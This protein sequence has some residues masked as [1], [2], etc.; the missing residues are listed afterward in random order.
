MEL[1]NFLAANLCL[2]LTLVVC[3]YMLTAQIL[4]IGPNMASRMMRHRTIREKGWPPA[5]LDADG[6]WAS[7]SDTTDDEESA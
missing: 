5:H 3:L 4:H 7:A 1:L 2:G 6:D